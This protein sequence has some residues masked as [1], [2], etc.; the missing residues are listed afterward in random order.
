MKYNSKWPFF[1]ENMINDINT[2]IRSG[3]VN[4]WTGGKVFEFQ[5]KFCD[6]FKCK[7]S[8]AVSNGTVALDL[9]LKALNLKQSDEVIVTS[10]SFIASASCCL[11]NDIKVNFAD[12]D[13][14]SQNITVESIKN[15]MNNNVKAIIVVHLAG[16]AADIE[17]I[18]NF[19]NNNNLY[20]IEDCAQCHGGKF[21]DK[22]LGTFGHINSWS[23][24]QDKIITT[25]GEG[26]MI[27]TNDTSLFKRA[28]SIKD[29]GKNYD[30]IFADLNYK[31]NKMQSNNFKF[32]HDNIGTNWRLTEVQAVT[33]LHSL[34]LLDEWVKIRRRNAQILTNKFKSCKL[35]RI[36]YIPE[37]IYHSYYKFYIFINT[38][39]LKE[40]SNRDS[41]LNEIVKHGI[42]CQQGSCGEIYKEN[43]FKNYKNIECS[44]S[45][46]LSQTAIMFKVDPSYNETEIEEIADICI[47]IFNNNTKLP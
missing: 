38:E 22:Y 44:N 40:N 5:N 41:I 8:V 45:I 17:N 7:H 37:Y 16:Y 18:L 9:C 46:K 29:H 2:V 20:L 23:F 27:T 47:T 36:P 39:N 12:V 19:C 15:V 31:R 6:Y 13:L 28:W 10:R 34:D 42:P 32:I 43:A 11:F 26:G 1:N 33:G 35:I 25:L 30:K 14:N 24:C 4:Q 21:K 3:K